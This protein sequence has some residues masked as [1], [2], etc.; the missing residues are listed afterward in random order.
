MENKLYKKCFKIYN[1]DIEQYKN[2]PIFIT[3]KTRQIV[4]KKFMKWLD[5]KWSVDSFLKNSDRILK[6]EFYL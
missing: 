1:M 5:E 4:A 6:K 3:L 2:T